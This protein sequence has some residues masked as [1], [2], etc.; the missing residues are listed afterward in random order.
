MQDGP[1]RTFYTSGGKVRCD[2]LPDLKFVRLSL[3]YLRIVRGGCFTSMV[4]TMFHATG[5]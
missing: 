3:L 5:E 4:K 1:S 2:P